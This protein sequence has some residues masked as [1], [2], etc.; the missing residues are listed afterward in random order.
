MYLSTASVKRLSLIRARALRTTET[1]D[2]SLTNG[3]N[4]IPIIQRAIVLIVLLELI[5]WADGN[6][7]VLLSTPCRKSESGWSKPCTL[8][9]TLCSTSLWDLVP[10]IFLCCSTC[11]TFSTLLAILI[12]VQSMLNFQ[13]WDLP[14]STNL[15]L[16]EF[17]FVYEYFVVVKSL[18]GSKSSAKTKRQN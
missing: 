8:H 18:G 9:S 1:T 12:V 2:T 13:V 16:K 3:H 10:D 17:P 11:N 7:F 6:R 15:V 5:Y 14:E 4:I